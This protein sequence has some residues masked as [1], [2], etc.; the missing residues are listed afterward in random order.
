MTRLRRRNIWRT[1]VI[2]PL[3][4]LPLVQC[5]SD[6]SGDNEG[7]G[8]ESGETVVTFWHNQ[9]FWKPEG[10][11]GMERIN[12]FNEEHKGEIKVE[13]NWFPTDQYASVLQTAMSSDTLPDLFATPQLDLLGM[14]EQGLIRPVNDIV[15]DDWAGQFA[16]G[17]FVEGINKLGD[18]YYSWPERGPWDRGLM[19]TN[20]KVMEQAGLDPDQP[21]TTW[22]ELEDMC[23]DIA[24][25]GQGQYYGMIIGGKDDGIA[26]LE[27]L[28]LAAG[29]QMD[30]DWAIKATSFFDYK[31]GTYQYDSEQMK[32]AAE[33]L[34]ELEDSGCVVPGSLSRDKA[35]AEGLWAQGSAAFHF[36]PQWVINIVKRDFPDTD[37]SVSNVPTPDAGTTPY[38]PT[39]FARGDYAVSAKTEHAEAVGVVIEELLTGPAAFENFV[40]NGI[41]LSASDEWNSRDDLYPHEQFADYVELSDQS[42]RIAPSPA[43]R[44]QAAA[45]VMAEMVVAPTKYE[46]MQQIFTGGVDNLDENLAAYNQI[47]EDSLDAAIADVQASG[48]EVSRDDFIFPNWEPSENYTDEK[49]AELE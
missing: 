10:S 14:E 11:V 44:S 17:A 21:P 41:V 7:E 5:S 27:T 42:V 33:F 34:L 1:A 47:L 45:Q 9:D 26:L 8:E 31:T 16:E 48:A 4:I 32:Q 28:A 13:L 39:S 24:E 46:A 18:D 15:P 43:A 6:D 12:E 40:K 20:R 23:A 49:Y 30:G 36:E 19:F 37:F 25:A 29:A 38:F 35:T 3:L 2:A 22:Q